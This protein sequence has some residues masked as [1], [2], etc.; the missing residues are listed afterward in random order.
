MDFTNWNKTEIC[1]VASSDGFW[2]NKS[3]HRNHVTE[4]K[5]AGLT[6][7]AEHDLPKEKENA[8][9]KWL[10]LDKCLLKVFE[11]FPE[12]KQGEAEYL[13]RVVA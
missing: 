1:D 12:H 11:K 9:Q 8:Y 5:R 7:N 3:F 2:N 13:F 6:C 4:A 10:G